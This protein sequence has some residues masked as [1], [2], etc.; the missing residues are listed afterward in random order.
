MAKEKSHEDSAGPLEPKS[1][2]NAVIQEKN[3]DF[4]ED[5]DKNVAHLNSVEQLSKFRKWYT[6]C[7][8]L[9]YLQKKFPIKNPYVPVVVSETD[10]RTC[11]D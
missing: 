8:C 7:F 10:S 6:C 5:L 9:T 3:R 11:I 4:G 1:R 2:E